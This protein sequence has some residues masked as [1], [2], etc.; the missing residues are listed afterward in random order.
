MP[1]STT[2]IAQM[3]YVRMPISLSEGFYYRSD[4]DASGRRR[5]AGQHGVDPRPVLF[6]HFL[7]P[8]HQ[9]SWRVDPERARRPGIDDQLVGDRPLDRQR[10]PASHP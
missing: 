10:L 7:G 3:M 4:P 9:R 2:R 1:P 8:R 5:D 6:D